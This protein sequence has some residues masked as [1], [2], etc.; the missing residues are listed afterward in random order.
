MI[1]L[2]HTVKQATGLK[3]SSGV[4]HGG[5]FSNVDGTRLWSREV[6]LNTPT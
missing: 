6:V 3:T 2:Q 4:S 5:Y 1:Q